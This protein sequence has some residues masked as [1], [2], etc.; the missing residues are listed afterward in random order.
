MATL[1]ARLEENSARDDDLKSSVYTSFSTSGKESLDHK[2]LHVDS[3]KPEIPYQQGIWQGAAH[4]KCCKCVD[5]IATVIIITL[6]WAI[7]ALPT[8]M[9]LAVGVS[10]RKTVATYLAIQYCL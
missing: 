1:G 7:M 2:S 8:I 10:K 9:Y 5:I 3:D 4:S 6:V